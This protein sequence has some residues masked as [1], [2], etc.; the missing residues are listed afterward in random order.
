MPPPPPPPVQRPP[1]GTS[2]FLG[3]AFALSVL[4]NLAVG[5]LLIVGCLGLF[6]AGGSVGETSA[7]LGTMTE[8]TFSGSSSSK[9]RVAI[10]TLDGVIMEG[11]LSFVNKQIEHA[12]KDSTS[13][14]WS[15]ALTVRAAA[16]PPATSCIAELTELQEWQIR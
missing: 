3:C 14:R 10:I 16:S 6:M 7:A 5:L 15:C 12:A 1:S 8:K 13:R 9:D 2:S 11:M 4:L